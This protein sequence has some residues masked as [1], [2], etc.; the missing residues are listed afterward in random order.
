MKR[1]IAVVTATRAE[2]GL[3]KP[4]IA[5]LKNIEEFETEVIP[6]FV[7]TDDFYDTEFPITMCFYSFKTEKA[8]ETIPDKGTPSSHFSPSK[9]YPFPQ[10]VLI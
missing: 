7:K 1:K 4:I 3:L 2:F 10:T 6:Y 5:A 8:K 9:R